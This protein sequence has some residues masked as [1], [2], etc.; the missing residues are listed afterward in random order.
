METKIT[1]TELARNLSDI[2]NRVRYR[3]ERFVVERNG[4][5]VAT[6]EPPPT[7]GITWR[8]FLERWP[9]LPKPDPDFWDDVEEAHR[10]MNQPP[11]L[12]PSWES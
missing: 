7:K 11:A 5:V 12:P 4:E 9:T 1:A 10:I 6:L 8:E 2:L 3:G